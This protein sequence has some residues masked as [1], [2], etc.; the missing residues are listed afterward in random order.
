M[1]AVMMDT[2]RRSSQPTTAGNALPLPGHTDRPGN[3]SGAALI[4]EGRLQHA[5][6]SA[7]AATAHR[8]VALRGPRLVDDAGSRQPG[9][10][11][12]QL[13]G[14]TRMAGE[15]RIQPLVAEHVSQLLGALISDDRYQLQPRGQESLV[16]SGLM[17]PD[18][19]RLP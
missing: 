5:H 15:E 13:L 1:W 3:L 11:S 17:L 10:L 8:P 9:E 12:A 4:G 14:R 19:P 2:L 7:V 6:R 16:V 18:H